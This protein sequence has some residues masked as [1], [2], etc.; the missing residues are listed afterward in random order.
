M[1][2]LALLFVALTALA[3]WSM[4]N[5]NPSA[6]NGVVGAGVCAVI[7]AALALIER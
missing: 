1:R 5:G 6:I 7:C 4:A 2:L 3:A